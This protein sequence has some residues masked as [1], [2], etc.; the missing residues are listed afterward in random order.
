MLLVA[1]TK[2]VLVQCLVLIEFQQRIDISINLADRLIV[3]VDELGKLIDL[4][5]GFRPSG[6]KVSTRQARGGNFSQKTLFENIH[7]DAILA[8]LA[9]I[10]LGLARDDHQ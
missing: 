8:R 10:L 9:N 2:P 3:R 4:S 6:I 1:I 5:I 7:W